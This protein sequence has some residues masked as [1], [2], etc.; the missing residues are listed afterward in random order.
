MT[1]QTSHVYENKQYA[2][3]DNGLWCIALQEQTPWLPT[4]TSVAHIING[5]LNTV[6]AALTTTTIQMTASGSSVTTIQ[7]TGS[8]TLHLNLSNMHETMYDLP[9]LAGLPD[10][11]ANHSRSMT[12]DTYTETRDDFG[13]FSTTE[14]DHNGDGNP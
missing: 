6:G 1:G 10:D 9:S 7:S 8:E 12:I 5:T 14:W 4:G 13:T 11:D 2:S 3:V